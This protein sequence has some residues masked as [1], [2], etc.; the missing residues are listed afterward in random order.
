M[1]TFFSKWRNSSGQQM[2]E[3]MFNFVSRQVNAVKN[4]NEI[5][6]PL[7]KKSFYQKDKNVTNIVEGVKK[8]GLSYSL[9]GNVRQPSH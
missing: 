2:Y 3:K 1:N 6:F 9:G 5:S 4:H 8:R 7:V